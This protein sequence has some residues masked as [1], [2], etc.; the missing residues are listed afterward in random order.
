MINVSIE[1]IG[2]ELPY[3]DSVSGKKVFMA[4]WDEDRNDSTVI[5]S[6][7]SK[8]LVTLEK[9][10][11]EWLKAIASVIRVAEM[12]GHNTAKILVQGNKIGV[13]SVEN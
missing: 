12:S 10:T 9:P 3:Y 7:A 6:T 8:F 11:T 4:L 1:Q 5:I 2:E 13:Y